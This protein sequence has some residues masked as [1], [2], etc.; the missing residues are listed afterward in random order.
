MK[1][2]WVLVA[3]RAGARLYEKPSEG[4]LR[5]LEEIAHPE[6]RLRDREIDTDRAGASFHSSKSAHHALV[7]E[8]RAHEHDAAAFAR[9][10]ARRLSSGRHSGR[11]DELML[12]AEPHF[13][14]VL[15]AA[16]DRPTASCVSGTMPKDYAWVAEHDL[17]KQLETMFPEEP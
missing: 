11:F 17:M 2:T 14:G 12:V 16:L 9:A 8:E 7:G 15:R 10:L 13:L 3:Q 5:F 6:G 1:T 4:E